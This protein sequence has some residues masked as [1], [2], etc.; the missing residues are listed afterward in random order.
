MLSDSE[1]GFHQPVLELPGLPV[2]KNLPSPDE[3]RANDELHQF[4]LQVESIFDTEEG[5]LKRQC[6]IEKLEMVLREW[7]TSLAISKEVSAEAAAKGG[8]IQILLFGSTK[9]QVNNSDSDIDTLC[10][11]PSFISR[12]DFFE[13]FCEHLSKCEGVEALL[14]IPDAYTPVIKFVYESHSVDMVFAALNLSPLPLPID[15]LDLKVLRGLDEQSVR[16]LN[17]VRVAEWICKLVPNPHSYRMALRVIKYWAKQ[18]G[19]YSSVLGFLG[20]INFAILVA[21]ISRLYINACPFTLIQKFF[22]LYSTWPWPT[23][24]MLRDY[25]DL[26]FRDSDGRY[27][28]VWNSFSNYKDALHLMPIIT[29]AYPA[30]N[31]AYNV[32]RPQFRSILSEFVRAH[33]LF[34]NHGTRAH[35]P[36]ENLFESC[37][38]EFFRSHPRYIQVLQL[39]LIVFTSYLFH[40]FEISSSLDRYSSQNCSRAAS[41]VR[42]GRVPDAIFDNRVREGNI[43]PLGL[44][45]FLLTI[46][47]VVQPPEIFSHPMANCFHR[48]PSSRPCSPTFESQTYSTQRNLQLGEDGDVDSPPDSKRPTVGDKSAA[49]EKGDEV[50]EKSDVLPAANNPF[51]TPTKG[52][53]LNREGSDD[54]DGLFISSFFIG[55]SFQ[56]GLMRADISR[57]INVSFFF[58]YFL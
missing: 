6:V 33:V 45:T 25:E 5:S 37:T 31:S 14:S 4:M 22:A 11:S 30:M 56:D 50:S 44:R 43:S 18:R 48:R 51:V 55:L 40:V 10:V 32:A 12:T 41:L 39:L 7:A 54:T 58:S 46:F 19:L 23:P 28:P 2:T 29:P 13:S 3:L 21:Q 15:L 53:I 9:L 36:W 24:V 16:S 38:E 35:F 20:G 52:K 57:E 17:G 34:Q 42:L 47:V 49:V 27:L 8:G 26:K 1:A